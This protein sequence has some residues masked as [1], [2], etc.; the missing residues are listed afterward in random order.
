MGKEANIFRVKTSKSV[1]ETIRSIK[2]NFTKGSDYWKEG[3]FGSVDGSTFKCSHYYNATKD[4]PGKRNK[5][6][7][8]G[9]VFQENGVTIIECEVKSPYRSIGLRLF[10]S[11][12]I[13]IATYLRSLWQ[14]PGLFKLGIIAS[15][16]SFLVMIAMMY[17]VSDH[18]KQ[19]YVKFLRNC[20]ARERRY[21][22]KTK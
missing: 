15:I 18:A 8:V 20:A 4:N 13:L 16:I 10:I 21:V 9:K 3:M 7:A 1:E 12:I 19:P 14:S 6:T 22:I 17:N 2:S 5:C 11:I